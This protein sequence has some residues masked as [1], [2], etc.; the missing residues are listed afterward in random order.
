MENM[1]S[2]IRNRLAIASG[3][4]ATVFL[5]ELAGG[6]LT[7][8]LAL[9]SDA[10]HVFM[11]FLA[12]SLSLAAIYVSQLPPTEERTYGLH[13]VEVFAAFVNGV[14]ILAIAL[15]IFYKA[16]GRFLNPEEVETT[17][18]LI[19]A[20]FGFFVNIAVVLYLMGFAKTDLNV[21]S[22]FFHVIGD[23]LASVGVVVGAVIIRLTGVWAVD[24]FI[25]FLIAAI[26]VVGSVRIIGESS[27]ILL[28]G[29]PRALDFRRVLGDIKSLEGVRGVHNLHIWSICH[30]VHALSAHVE[31]DRAHIERQTEV[32][33]KISKALAESH[34][35]FYTT[36]QVECPECKEGEVLRIIEHRG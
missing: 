5:V 29:V 31:I 7:N 33:K 18:M 12:I 2:K 35:I 11:D 13:R 9:L 32:L 24:P 3:A 17:G 15:F 26:I 34:R 25:S 28:E 23:A 22:A 21:K 10:A 14:S 36:I 20:V 30:N 8:S 19:V 6:Y 1:N 16:Y 4:T 27:H